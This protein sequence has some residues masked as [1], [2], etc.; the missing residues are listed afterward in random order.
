[1][2]YSDYDPKETAMKIRG[3]KGDKDRL[4]YLGGG[5]DKPLQEW[6]A[7]RGKDAG[8]LFCPISWK[9]KLIER[10]LSDQ[11]IAYLLVQRA[12]QAGLERTS[13]HDFRRTFISNLLD[14]GADIATVQQLAGHSSVTTTARYDRR[15]AEAKK[16]AARLISVPDL[17]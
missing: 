7:I 15:G 17:E 5:V 14:A 3:G 2:D 13:P 11:S 6:L 10:R 8:A 4:V 9:G 1:L 12:K 16:K